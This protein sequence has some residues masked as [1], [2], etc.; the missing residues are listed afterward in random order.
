MRASESNRLYPVAGK[1]LFDA[2]DP[3]ESAV[4]HELRPCFDFLRTPLSSPA[5]GHRE[6]QRGFHNVADLVTHVGCMACRRLAALLCANARNDQLPD[7][8]LHQ[9]DVKSAADKC[10]VTTLMKD[11]IRCD[12]YAF[13]CFH[14]TGCDGEGA[15][16]FYMEDLHHWDAAVLGS[17]DERLQPVEKPRHI[18]I[19][20]IWT[21]AKGLLRIDDQE[22]HLRKGHL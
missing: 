17:I 3:G 5:I 10:A 1:H 22:R 11:G 18:A 21:M 15:T 19:A 6:S 8:V 9:P 12:Q 7:A 13:D 2:N 14:V 20:P 16:L 4:E